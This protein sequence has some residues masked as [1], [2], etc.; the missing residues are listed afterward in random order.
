VIIARLSGGLGNQLFQYAA[1]RRLALR[2][3][4][5]LKLDLGLYA[6]GY[7]RSYRLFHLAVAA[8]PASPAEIRRL[9]GGDWP[10]GR[11]YRWLQARRPLPRRRW[12]AERRFTFDPEVLEL[13]PAVY[14]Q[15]YWQSERYFADSAAALRR[16]LTVATPPSAANR[17]L[18]GVIAATI[19]VSVHVRRSDYLHPGVAQVHGVAGPDYYRQAMDLVAGRSPGARFYLFSDDLGWA[20]ANIGFGHPVEYVDVNG[21]EA[22]YED[23]RLMGLCRHHIIANSSFSWWAAWLGE[24]PDTMVIAPAR[25]FA[26]R[27][28]DSRDLVPERWIRL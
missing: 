10:A 13:G 5:P 22:E 20:R 7:S 16:E 24:G 11:L 1:A 25:W 2:H 28:P 15:G 8:A 9:R 27:G 23:L 19:A 14:L 26:E 4:V 6:P 12:V 17:E 18:A 3:G 21:P